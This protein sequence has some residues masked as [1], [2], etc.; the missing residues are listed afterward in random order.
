MKLDIPEEGAV[1]TNTGLSYFY[2]EPMRL[3]LTVYCDRDVAGFT[4]EVNDT[5]DWE[6]G[7]SMVIDY[8]RI[9]QYN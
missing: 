8:V 2:N 9:Y 3:V 5:T 6:N 1:G 4:G 7:S